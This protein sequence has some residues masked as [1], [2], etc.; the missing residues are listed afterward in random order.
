VNRIGATCDLIL[1]TENGVTADIARPRGPSA[2]PAA[3]R[4]AERIRDE[5]LV[6]ASQGGD[7]EAFE[8]LIRRWRPVM[9]RHAW[10][11]AGD[12]DAAADLVQESCL[13]VVRG[14][15]RLHDPAT[16][17]PWVLRIVSN[18]A[19]DWV[20][21]RRRERRLMRSAEGP[22]S[23]Q[24]AG[25]AAAGAVR[26]TDMADVI[27]Q[28]VAALPAHLRAVVGLYYGEGLSVAEAASALGIPPG[29]IKSRLHEAR[30]R[31]KGAIE[32]RLT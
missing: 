5:W 12:R 9:A 20:R 22:M 3:A 18:K 14:L 6:L 10:R 27:R 24:A 21:R 4:T 13:A 32:G 7:V 30:H 23:G 16:F 31:I 17:G 29:T 11:L 1:R 26:H 19:A 15:G 25:G 2:A 28:T 8:T